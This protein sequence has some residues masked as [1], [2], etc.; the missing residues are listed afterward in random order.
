MHIGSSLTGC[1]LTIPKVVR[2][3]PHEMSR[4]IIRS[5][6]ACVCLASAP[7]NTWAAEPLKKSLELQALSSVVEA[8]NEGSMN[9]LKMTLSGLTEY[10]KSAAS[11]IEGTVSGAEIGDLDGNGFPEVYAYVTSA[12][13]GSYGSPVAYVVNN[14]NSMTLI[15]LPPITDDAKASKGYMG[16]DEF[17]VLEN[18]LRR[19]FPIYKEGDTNSNPPGK[20]RQIQYKLVPTEAE[21]VLRLNDITE[22]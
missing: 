7:A 20:S 14:G 21:W 12:G 15:C 11:E 3:E 9:Q 22:F 13:S 10:N 17:A 6:L 16:H 2:H 8:T 18:V 1:C 19:C 4:A 5:L